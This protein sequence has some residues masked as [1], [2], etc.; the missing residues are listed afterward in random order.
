VVL[1]VLLIYH[2]ISD[3]DF[4][5]LLTLSSLARMAGFGIVLFGFFREKNAQSLSLKTMQL[6]VAVHF[7]RLC[8]ILFYEGYLPYDSTGDWVYQSSEV[9]SLL[10]VGAIVFMIMSMRRIKSTYELTSNADVLGVDRSSSIIPINVPFVPP[11]LSAL[12]IVVPCLVLAIIFHPSLNNNIFTDIAWTSALY[13]ESL[14]LLP[15]LYL[16]HKRQAPVRAMNADYIFM[17]SVSCT[18]SVI[19]WLA[20]YAELNDRQATH[21]TGAYPGYLVLICQIVQVLQLARFMWLYIVGN[22]SV[23]TQTLLP[24]GH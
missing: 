13:I 14:A 22:G 24:L 17:L 5:F 12:V 8:S 2:L 4:S 10:E 20:S 15:Q 16:L 23:R 18:L 6:Y 3:G 7:L 11:H 1:G 9:A 21:I 19:F